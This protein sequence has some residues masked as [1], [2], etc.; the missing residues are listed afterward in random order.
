MPHHPNNA[1]VRLVVGEPPVLLVLAL[2]TAGKS[3]AQAFLS[4]FK[5]PLGPLFWR[6][7]RDCSVSPPPRDALVP[8]SSQWPLAGLFPAAP[9]LFSWESGRDKVVKNVVQLYSRVIVLRACPGTGLPNQCNL[10]IPLSQQLSAWCS[11]K[12]LFFPL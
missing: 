11:F 8:D 10:K 4:P 9:S 3:L 12:L 6:L 2:G 5:V 7:S 1:E